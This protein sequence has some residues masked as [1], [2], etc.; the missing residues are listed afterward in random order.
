MS[1][2]QVRLLH[3]FFPVVKGQNKPTKPQGKALGHWLLSNY[4]G[5]LS[6]NK[7]PLSKNQISIKQKRSEASAKGAKTICARLLVFHFG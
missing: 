5:N 4:K 7:V 6:A 3:L 1:C 2:D